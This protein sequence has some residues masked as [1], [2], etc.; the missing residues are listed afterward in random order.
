MAQFKIIPRI[1]EGGWIVKS[2]VGQNTPVL[3]GRKITTKYFRSVPAVHLVPVGHVLMSRV[4]LFALGLLRLLVS[5]CQVLKHRQRRFCGKGD[6][7]SPVGCVLSQSTYKKFPQ[8]G[9]NQPK[10]SPQ[11]EKKTKTLTFPQNL[12]ENKKETPPFSKKGKRM[13]TVQRLPPPATPAASEGCGRWS[14]QTVH[15][16]PHGVGELCELCGCGRWSLQTVHVVPHG[17]GEWVSCPLKKWERD[18]G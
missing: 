16:V 10:K 1:E 15:V 9:K 17:V 2:A 3:L 8:K 6:L 4:V 7:C 12:K 14:L 11:G 5:G 18:G 13:R